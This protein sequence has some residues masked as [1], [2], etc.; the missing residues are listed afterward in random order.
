MSTL[1][2]I[3]VMVMAFCGLWAIGWAAM[4]DFREQTKDMARKAASAR[5][6]AA[7]DH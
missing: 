1:W 6:L 5:A 2:T 4:D 7:L 3:V